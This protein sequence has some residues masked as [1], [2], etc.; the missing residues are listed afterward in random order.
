MLNM[1]FRINKP[2]VAGGGP[3]NDGQFEPT[4]SPINAVSLANSKCWM[5]AGA[6]GNPP[7]PLPGPPFD[8]HNPANWVNLEKS[9]ALIPKLPA[10]AQG[11]PTG[12][13]ISIRIA[14]SPAHPLPAGPWELDYAVAYGRPPVGGGPYASPFDETLTKVRTTF[15]KEKLQPDIDANG[16]VRGWIIILGQVAQR[17]SPRGVPAGVPFAGD[18]T[19]RYEFALGVIVRNRTT[20]EVWHFGEDPEDDVGG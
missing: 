15:I 20:G 14:P 19:H 10:P 2:A 16:N 5:R 13:E 3:P 8:R 4:P 11:Q 12:H 9:N 18:L 17:A 1:L 7:E 6:A